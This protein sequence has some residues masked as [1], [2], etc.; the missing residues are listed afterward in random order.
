MV[1]FRDITRMKVATHMKARR[2]GP[3]E[4]RI[5]APQWA[6]DRAGE[7]AQEIVAGIERLG[8]RVIGDLSSLT[9]VP[10]G[11]P[12]DRLPLASV[13][14]EVAA[15]MAMGIVEASRL[16]G[17]RAGGGW[18]EPLEIARVPTRELVK[19]LARRV[20]RASAEVLRSR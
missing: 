15:L 19:A 11:L 10:R 14:P 7:I 2:P 1:A 3:D 18:I 8:V 6:L 9:A 17:R 12:G 13:S 20:A 5:E 16:R 4:A